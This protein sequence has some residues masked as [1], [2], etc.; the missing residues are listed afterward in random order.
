MHAQ[1]PADGE[2]EILRYLKAMNYKKDAD[3]GQTNS[4]ANKRESCM[5]DPGGC[6]KAEDVS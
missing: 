5:Y 6:G 1:K 2:S 3:Q 4:V